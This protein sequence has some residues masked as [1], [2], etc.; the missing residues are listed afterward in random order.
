MALL[1]GRAA[2]VGRAAGGVA[3]TGVIEAYG[4]LRELLER[5]FGHDSAV[6]R[7]V[8]EVEAN[9]KYAWRVRALSD[10][11]VQKGAHQDPDLLRAAQDLTDKV[12]TQ[13][14][15]ADIIERV[16]ADPPAVGTGGGAGEEVWGLAATVLS[17][18]R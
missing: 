8:R 17:R 3:E 12:R 16:A 6:M 5:K 11:L 1:A 9:P 10:E 14:G 2:G 4:A 7:A 15:G 18:L 13:P